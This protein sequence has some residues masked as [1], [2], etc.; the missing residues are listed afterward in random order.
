M[1]KIVNKVP[2]SPKEAGSQAQSEP[3]V[4]QMPDSPVPKEPKP[5]KS[6]DGGYIWV[7]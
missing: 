4:K 6:N 1:E 2:S 3:A 5:S 7:V